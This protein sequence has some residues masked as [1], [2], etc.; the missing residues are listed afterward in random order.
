MDINAASVEM[1]EL[2]TII[3]KEKEKESSQ[4]QQIYGLRQELK[5]IHFEL[6]NLK[7]SCIST[8]KNSAM[9]NCTMSLYVITL[10]KDHVRDIVLPA[11]MVLMQSTVVLMLTKRRIDFLVYLLLEM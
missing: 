3:N 5:K 1:D 11:S 9:K 10:K 2:N 7:K 8:K 4:R 6:I